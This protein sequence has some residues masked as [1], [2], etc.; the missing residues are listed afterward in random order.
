MDSTKSILLTLRQ[1]ILVDI[2][3]LYILRHFQVFR[4]KEIKLE[5][6]KQKQNKVF[7]LFLDFGSSQLTSF[8]LILS[9]EAAFYKP[10]VLKVHPP[11]SKNTLHA[12]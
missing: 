11:I 8:M 9:Y 5:E 2:R 3:S 1:R 12:R 7:L 6:S 10:T 4:R